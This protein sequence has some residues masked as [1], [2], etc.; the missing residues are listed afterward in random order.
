MGFEIKEPNL[1]QRILLDCPFADD[2]CAITA[3]GTGKSYGIPLMIARDA[4]H[5]RQKYSCLVTRQSFQS[6]VE[7]QGLLNTYL[8]RAFPGTVWHSQSNFFKLGGKESPLG[9]VELAY[10]GSGPI[11]QRKALDRLQGRSFMCHIHDE[12]GTHPTTD[13]IDTV[14]AT[15]RAPEG[16]PTRVILLGNPGGAGHAWLQARFGIPAG[17]P[18]PGQPRRFYSDDLR[19]HC[20][21]FSA[22][23]ASNSYIALDEYI[24]SIRVS[25]GDD[26]ALLDAW[27]RG[28]LDVEIAGAFFGTSLNNRRSLRD[29][30]PGQIN[31]R[32]H[33]PFVMFDYGVAAPS[34][35]YLCVPNPPDAPKGSMLLLDELYIC[36]STQ[37]GQRDYSRGSYLST[38]EQAGAVHEW[39]ERWGLKASDI[40]IAADD[41]I[42]NNDGRPKGSVAGDFKA[43]GINVKRAGKLNTRQANGLS[44]VRTMLKAAGEDPGTPWLLWTHACAGWMSTVPTIPRHPSDVELIAPGCADHALDAARYAVTYQASRLVSHSTNFAIW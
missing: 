11:E 25:A 39:L 37:G 42:F 36:P 19:K 23:A 30:N 12:I 26:P 28:R 3:R 13:F 27:L 14:R 15:L 1:T 33:D 32:K 7:L 44:M 10:T 41:A 22:T 38:A 2:V 35:F 43:A 18:E 20:V 21:F 24:R 17:Y 16:I 8:T 34:V 5:F 40:T 4:S 29:I 6:L 31:L 9:I